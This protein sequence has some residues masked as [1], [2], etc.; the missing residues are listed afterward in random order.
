MLRVSTVSDVPLTVCAYLSGLILLTS[1]TC[2]APPRR[3]PLST[4]RWYTRTC[5]CACV[6]PSVR[7]LAQS[8]PNQRTASCFSEL[9]RRRSCAKS[10]ASLLCFV[11][12]DSGHLARRARSL[13]RLS[14]MR[15]S[16]V[17]RSTCSASST[18]RICTISVALLP[19]SAT[20]RSI[21]S[22]RS[23]PSGLPAIASRLTACAIS[24]I[25]SAHLSATS[26]ANVL[27]VSAVDDALLTNSSA[28]DI[29]ASS[30]ADACFTSASV[31]SFGFSLR[32][33]S[34]LSV[35]SVWA[36]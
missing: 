29:P 22:P 5:I 6:R 9:A 3:L 31:V 36:V 4:E 28:F 1:E 7:E 2:H 24:P 10:H 27:I 12:S 26:V 18:T 15:S 35:W 23:K 33:T 34:A 13:T 21:A 16:L 19:A 30:A 32:L 14:L 8:A 11:S 17:Q 25:I 20:T